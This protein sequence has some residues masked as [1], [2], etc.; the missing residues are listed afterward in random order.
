LLQHLLSVIP[1]GSSV[2]YLMQQYITHNYPLSSQGFIERV[3]STKS[4][5]DWYKQYSTVA[6]AESIC[7]EFSSGV[8]LQNPIGLSLL[9]FKKIITA[10]VAKIARAVL[11]DDIINRYKTIVEYPVSDCI[12]HL[13][14]SNIQKI[15]KEIFRIDYIAP[16]EIFDVDL[17]SVSADFINSR[18][19]FEH[20]P[21]EALSAIVNRC[22][23]FLKKDGVAIISIDYRD[24][25]SFFDSKI[26]VFNFLKYPE[27]SWKRFNPPI[28]HQNRLRHVDYLRL[29]AIHGFQI[30]QDIRQLPNVDEN[31]QYSQITIDPYFIQNY[32]QDELKV[33]RGIFILKK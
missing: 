21:R 33:I 1:G 19:T 20:I 25:W 13:S 6:P 11:I 4:F 31:N 2:N 24:H 23:H 14:S 32:S 8:H 15:L 10:D 7:F 26:S 29:F 30:V 17:P 5:Y 12:P 27:N 28:H 18:T 3:K 9:G 16:I 22:Y